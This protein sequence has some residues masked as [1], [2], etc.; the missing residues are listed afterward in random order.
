M[1]KCRE[2]LAACQ[3]NPALSQNILTILD[4]YEYEYRDRQF[5]ERMEKENEKNPPG[6]INIGTIEEIDNKEK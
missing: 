6:V 1:V 3:H 2:K 4:A 5:M